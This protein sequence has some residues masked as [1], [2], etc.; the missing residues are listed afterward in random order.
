MM[1]ASFGQAS[2]LVSVLQELLLGHLQLPRLSNGA[3]ETVY[4]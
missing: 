4:S 1:I 3:N 2:L